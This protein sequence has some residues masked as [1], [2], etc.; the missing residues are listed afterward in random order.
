MSLTEIKKA[1]Q[2]LSLAEINE[3]TGWMNEQ[4]VR[5]EEA[6][7]DAWDKQFET[8][9][10]EGRLDYFFAEVHASIMAGRTYPLQ[11]DAAGRLIPPPDFQP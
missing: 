7:A 6:D 5:A 3:L 2:K 1:V 4:R 11:F 8:D 10:N 9:V